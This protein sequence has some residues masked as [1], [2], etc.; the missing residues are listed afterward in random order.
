MISE[1]C[2]V[3]AAEEYMYIAALIASVSL[4]RIHCHMARTVLEIC[5]AVF[6]P[7]SAAPSMEGFTTAGIRSP[8]CL[9]PPQIFFPAA[10]SHDNC[11]TIIN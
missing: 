8:D 11:I 7:S 3:T 4:F 6:H 10:G 9:L 2:S 1:D 5:G